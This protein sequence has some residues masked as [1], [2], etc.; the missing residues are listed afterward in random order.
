[1]CDFVALTRCC[2]LVSFLCFIYVTLYKAR[3]MNDRL[4]DQT[5]I[6]KLYKMRLMCLTESV[7]ACKQ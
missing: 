5:S 1:M 4:C 6:S 3:I 7:E 2:K